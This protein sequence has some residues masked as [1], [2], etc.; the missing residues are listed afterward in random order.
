MAERGILRSRRG[1]GVFVEAPPTEYSIGKRVRF[2]RNIRATG[3]LPQKQ[4]LRLETRPSDETEARALDLE[5][6]DLVLIYEGLS[7]SE[8]API[9]H[10]ISIFPVDRVP[11]MAATLEEVTSVTEALRRNGIYDYTRRDTRL[12]ALLADPVLALHLR[13]REGD[14][15]LKAVGLNITTDGTPIE[16]GKTCFAGDRVTLTVT[17]D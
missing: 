4:V 17:N 15:L 12:S 11:G 8:G 16:L 2:H 5:T 6:G 7:L 9:A 10:F 14:P 3:R 1:A 13:L